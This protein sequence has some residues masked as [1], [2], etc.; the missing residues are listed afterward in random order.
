MS[1]IFISYKKEEKEVAAKLAHALE[2]DGWTVWWDVEIPTGADF[3]TLIKETLG[4][5]DVTIV[6]W[7]KESIHSDWVRAEA[8][9]ARKYKKVFPVLIEELPH[10]DL[11]L[12]FQKLHAHDLANWSG[13]RSTPI[14]RSLQEP[15]QFTR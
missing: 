2:R 8:E 12:L 15:R 5:C 13:E 3:E 1:D 4:T 14:Q 11:P 6:L 9:Y 10:Q 7:S